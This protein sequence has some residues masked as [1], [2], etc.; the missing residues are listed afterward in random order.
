MGIDLVGVGI[1]L[2]AERRPV[3]VSLLVVESTPVHPR[4]KQPD[5]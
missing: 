4:C 5:L 3:T 2:R 1:R